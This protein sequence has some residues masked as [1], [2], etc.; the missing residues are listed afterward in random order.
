MMLSCTAWFLRLTGEELDRKKAFVG[1]LKKHVFFG[2]MGT[3]KEDIPT[4]SVF[5]SSAYTMRRKYIVACL[6]FFTKANFPDI[7]FG[8]MHTC[9]H[10]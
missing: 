5:T 6:Q 2:V 9:V 10:P 7:P 3:A 1:F 4:W 8:K